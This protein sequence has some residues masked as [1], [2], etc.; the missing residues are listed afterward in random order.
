MTDATA[1]PDF[2]S[3]DE[4]LDLHAEQLA[5]FGGSPGVRDQRA[6][7]SAVATPQ[8]T[9]DGQFLHDGVFKMAAAYAYH[10]AE[11]QAFVDG[12]KRTALNAALVFLDLNGWTVIDPEMRL[13]EAMI[14]FA[15]HALDKDGMAQLL[16][17]LASPLDSP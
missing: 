4:V 11:A 8:S 13:Y 1:T 7:E 6:L 3:L 10:I 2:L 14:G 16:R 9:F 5:R 17:E 12:N 15:T